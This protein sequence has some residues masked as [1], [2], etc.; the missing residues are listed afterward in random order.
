MNKAPFSPRSVTLLIAF[1]TALA[2]MS[3][4]LHNNDMVPITAGERFASNSYSI[5]AI[6]HSGFYDL[7]RRLDQPVSR[8]AGNALAAAGK[9]GVLIAA[10]PDLRHALSAGTLRFMDAPRLLIV[11]PKWRGTQDRNRS[12]WVSEVELVSQNTAQQVLTIAAGRE[13][14]LFYRILN[15]S[16]NMVWHVNEIGIEPSLPNVIQLIRSEKIMPIVGNRDNMLL[17]EIRTANENKIWV[18]S[19]PDILSNHGIV[20]GENAAFML[21]VI[22][23]L[24]KWNNSGSKTVI[25]FDETIHGFQEQPG[26]IFSLPFRFPF[27]IV[28][29]LTCITAAL[30]ILSG[31]GRFGVP[32]VPKPALGF[33]KVNLIG[34]S[35]RLLDYA[36]HHR[37]VLERYINMTLR[38]AAAALHAPH[39]GDSR[40]ERANLC[41][42]LDRV[43]RSRGVTASCKDFLI[44]GEHD[45]LFE[46]AINAH[47]WKKEILKRESVYHG[48]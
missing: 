26:S 36:G 3:V 21:S 16:E 48:S 41:K 39:F 30:L 29:V 46:R 4:L 20:K 47:D 38:S 42:W 8:N 11:L 22:D 31:T 44:D 27:V 5:S 12:L 24:R 45:R 2:A 1:T 17:G 28:T 15:D 33:G 7:L 25:V 37:A 35:A 6:G 23:S 40:A 43:G 32:I 10:E 34:N 13:S 14:A 19:D 9:Q 18:L